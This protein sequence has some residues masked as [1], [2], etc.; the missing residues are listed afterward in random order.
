MP[1]IYV[2]VAWTSW[3]TVYPPEYERVT[4][5]IVSVHTSLVRQYELDR[6]EAGR[7]EIV[8]DDPNGVYEPGNSASPLYLNVKR[9]RRFRV[10]AALDPD[11]PIPIFVGEID[12]IVPAWEGDYQT[13]TIDG[14]DFCEALASDTYTGAVPEE[15]AFYRINRLLDAWGWPSDAR[16]I[17]HGWRPLAAAALDGVGYYDHMQQ[18]AESDGGIFFFDQWGRAAFHDGQRR[19]TSYA[20]EVT[21][22]DLAGQIPYE[23]VSPSYGRE[24]LKNWWE[25]SREGGDTPQIAYDLD[26]MSEYRKRVGRKSTILATD[27]DCLAIAGWSTDH[28]KDDPMRF[29]EI[30]VN[31]LA[32]SVGDPYIWHKLLNLHISHRV[33]VYKTPRR[34]GPPIIIDSFIDGISHEIG[35]GAHWL[36][37]Y[38]LTPC[39]HATYATLGTVGRCELDQTA[40]LAF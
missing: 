24:L 29:Q 12:S 1:D 37:R 21:F 14:L 25:V 31:P 33:T 17:D 8:I 34:A 28:Y 35:P 9:G 39:T 11:N 26:S 36:I 4:G 15:L 3:P 20:S 32:L 19:L 16:T 23:D 6:M 5:N 10:L 38:R 40:F 22:G 27:S 7:S 2:D 18:A 13:S 30:V